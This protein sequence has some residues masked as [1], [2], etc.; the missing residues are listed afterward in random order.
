MRIAIVDDEIE[1]IHTLRGFIEQ[2]SE[3]LGMAVSA[4]GYTD[5]ASFLSDFSPDKYR[6]VFLDIYID[7]MDGLD[8]AKSIREASETT[9]IVFCTTSRENMPEAFRYHAFDY[10]TK[11]ISGER[12]RQLLSD[13]AKVIP[14]INRYFSFSTSRGDISLPFSEFMWAQNEGHYIR[15]KTRQGEE[16]TVRMAMKELLEALDGDKRFLVINKGIVVNMDRIRRIEKGVCTMVDGTVFSVKIRQGAKIE[17]AWHNYVF[18]SL[19]E[20]QK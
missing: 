15:I 19:R 2:A 7:S 10:V 1:A 5:S 11:P 6:I 9:M 13:A 16:Y 4:D 3:D 17:Q 20:G 18:D 14:Q 8:L 12:I